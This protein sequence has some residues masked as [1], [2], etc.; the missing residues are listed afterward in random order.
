MT[1]APNQVTPLDAAMRF[2]FHIG[3]HWHGASEFFP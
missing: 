2:C 1:N 3:H